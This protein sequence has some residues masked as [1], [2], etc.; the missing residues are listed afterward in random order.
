M[1]MHGNNY[2][3]PLPKLL[4][5][6]YQFIKNLIH[7]QT[8]IHLGEAK[9]EMVHSRLMKRL[10]TLK[11]QTFKDYIKHLKN[12]ENELSF[13]IN[14]LTTNKTNFFRESSHFDYLENIYC[15][16]LLNKY[17]KANKTI[18]IWS[19]AC[20]KGHE[21]YTLSLLFNLFCTHNPKIDYRIL[22]TD[23]DTNVLTEAKNGIY[24][25]DII[26]DI[27][28][29]YIKGQLLRQKCEST[30]MYKVESS[31]RNRIKIR[32]FNLTDPNFSFPMNFDIIFLRN[33][34]I[35]FTKDLIQQIINNMYH[36]LNPNGLLF[37]GVSENLLGIT[38]QF[39]SIQPSVYQ[40]VGG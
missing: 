24:S 27:P 37:I 16:N 13:F 36:C 11:L 35:Y 15:K 31:L 26:K 2:E 14:S 21:V 39:K 25:Q 19:A 28:Q 20:S 33:V 7:L 3:A 22:G 8:G 4:P 18:H 38:H 5:K 1:M 9:Q 17:D 40:K 30:Y 32:Q 10:R 34:M 6:E 12:N 29:K 23:I